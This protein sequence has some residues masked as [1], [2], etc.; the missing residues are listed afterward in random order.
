MK[1]KWLCAMLLLPM[2]F[3]SAFG[4]CKNEDQ[5]G[6]API[7]SLTELPNDGHTYLKEVGENMFWEKEDDASRSDYITQA[8]G[9]YIYNY[10]PSVL[11]E[12]DNTRYVYYCS[13]RYTKKDAG[14]NFQTK[15]F[16]YS[17]RSATQSG[18]YYDYVDETGI[19]NRITDYV[20][21]RKGVRVNGEWY[22]SEKSYVLAPE[23][24]DPYEWE[25]TCDPNV[26]KGKFAYDGHT[27]GYLMA[28]LACATRDN[29]YN[30][31][32]VAV[33]DRPE[34]PWI[35]CKKINPLVEY[36][37]EGA[38]KNMLSSYLWGFGQASMINLDKKG[39]ILMFFSIIGPRVSATTGEWANSGNSTAVARF[40]LSDMNNPKRE[41]YDDFISCTG[42][43]NALKQEV[44]VLTNGDYAYDDATDRIYMI[45]DSGSV[46][47][48]KSRDS[49]KKQV[50]DVFFD[51]PRYD[52]ESEGLSW[53]TAG[54]VRPVYTK[55]YTSNHNSC[56]IRDS[57]GH[58]FDSHNLEF[59][60]TSGLTAQ[61]MT[62]RFR[63]FVD[64]DYLYTFRILR[65][66]LTV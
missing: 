65:K 22:W 49:K 18:T 51:H 52:W 11:Q 26:V 20:A 54:T 33:A 50:G 2:F 37:T 30:H 46:A 23:I 63:G 10:A 62:Q 9:I 43:Q 27:Y 15:Q 5:K 55:Y 7:P 41:K 35:K 8:P 48:I 44:G 12:D 14:G 6:N 16:T 36:S 25:Q 38:P 28:Y 58:L 47:W 39:K 57:Y 17:G 24:G 53:T 60:I 4:G 42:I 66:T 34:G 3:C 32:C 59:A 45:G 29:T 13:N 40:D 19:K 61:L 21:F 31:V 64:S 56:V 1:K